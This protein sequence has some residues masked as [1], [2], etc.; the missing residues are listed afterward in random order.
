MSDETL[1]QDE[2]DALLSGGDAPV[3]KND[4]SEVRLYDFSNQEISVHAA[5]PAL[6]SLYERFAKKL[7]NSMYNMTSC[8]VDVKMKEIIPQKFSDYVSSLHMP[9]SLNVIK[10]SPLPGSGL[11]V[12]DP[13]FVFILV[14][15]YF[16]GD[17]RFNTIIE[18]KEFTM[19]E[20]RVVNI[21][22]SAIF[23]DLK[24]AWA[25]IKAVEFDLIKNEI[26]PQLVNITSPNEIVFIAPFSVKFGGGAGELQIVLPYPM[27]NLAKEEL[28]SRAQHSGEVDKRWVKSLEEQIEY[29]EVELSSVLVKKNMTLRHIID[30]A[31]GDIIPVEMPEQI[32]IDIEGIPTFTAKYGISNEKC[33]LKIIDKA[34]R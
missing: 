10:V 19:T 1:S 28:G 33:S 25:P 9:I 27:L 12:L 13:E 17:G 24:T 31:V 30:L 14:E 4:S 16:G 2:V 6:W 26:N 11:I 18:T 8:E 22:L 21:L 5:F 7:D 23:Q 34:K 3:E 20:L 15:N 32:D 29:A